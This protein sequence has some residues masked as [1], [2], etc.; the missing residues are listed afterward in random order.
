MPGNT[1]LSDKSISAKT[2]ASLFPTTIFNLASYI[3][4]KLL[5]IVK[6]REDCCAA[7]HMV[8]KSQTYSTIEWVISCHENPMDRETWQAIVHGVVKSWTWLSDWAGEKE[9]EDWGLKMLQLFKPG[10]QTND[11]LYRQLT[12]TE[13]P[14]SLAAKVSVVQSYLSLCD[15]MNCSLPLLYSWHSQPTR[16]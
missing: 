11:E 16:N 5:Q 2:Q 15:S 13:E 9:P 6:D 10:R 1:L 4:Y 8:T 12:E 3:W 7:V 14:W